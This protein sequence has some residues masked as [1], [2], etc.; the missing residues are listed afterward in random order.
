MKNLYIIT[1]KLKCIIATLVFLISLNGTFAQNVNVVATIGTLNGTYL[2]LNSCFTAINNGTHGG[3]ITITIVNSTTEPST[4]IPLNASGTGLSNYNNILIKPSGNVTVNA[5]TTRITNRS[6]IEFNG[7]DNITIDGDDA[8]TVGTRNLTFS[9][10]MSTITNIGHIKFGSNSNSDGATNNKVQ[11]CVFIGPRNGVTTPTTLNYAIVIGGVSTTNI[12][13]PGFLNSNTTI[14][15]NEFLRFTHA[16]QAIGTTNFEIET[17]KIQNNIIGNSLDANNVTHTGI[18]ITNTCSNAGIA[19]GTFALIEGNDIQVGQTSVS[20]Y[21]ADAEG[22]EL[23][24]GTAGTIIRFN[25]IRN[26]KNYTALT[27][28][29]YGINLSGASNCASVEISNN[30]IRDIV[31]RRNIAQFNPPPVNTAYGIR[32]GGNGFTNLKIENNTIVL[33]EVPNQGTT[34]N[35]SNYGLAFTNGASNL[36]SLQNNIF[37]N[38]NIGLNTFA[39]FLF[40]QNMPASALINNNSYWVPSGHV[41]VLGSSTTT[42]TT[43]TNWQDAIQREYNSIIENPPFVSATDLHITTNAVSKL[44]AGGVANGMFFDIDLTARNLT[45]PD[46][47]ADE[48]IGS[49]LTRATINLVSHTAATNPCIPQSRT[50]SA[51]LSPGNALDSVILVYNFDGGANT[52]VRMTTTGGNIYTGSIPVPTPTNALVSYRSEALMSAENTTS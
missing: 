38:R 20:G 17:L 51:T 50:I 15:N 7:A 27:F 46:I 19:N 24:T 30:F 42:L 47:G 29:V 9:S 3:N 49:A 35:Y 12:L 32:V 14:F 37:V 22:I 31:A 28:G 41:G 44:K 6:I 8:N 52:R 23:G 45:K 10:A 1:L 25:N 18:F 26:I 11:N 33:N 4:P 39:H 21:G 36:A 5:S 48:F 34:L 43:L 40:T 13:N 2:N 16:I